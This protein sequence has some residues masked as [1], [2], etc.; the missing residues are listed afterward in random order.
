MLPPMQ[1]SREIPMDTRDAE[2]SR[3]IP[4]VPERYI[5]SITRSREIPMDT[6]IPE[7]CRMFPRDA[8]YSREIHN[9]NHAF[10]IYVAIKTKLLIC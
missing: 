10:F 3:E 9:I 2:C 4:N 5:I 8:E 7:R 1:R 6:S